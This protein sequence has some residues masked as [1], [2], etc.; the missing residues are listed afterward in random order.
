LPPAAKTQKLDYGLYMG[1]LAVAGLK[2]TNGDLS[3]ADRAFAKS[4][5][6]KN[7]VFNLA[8]QCNS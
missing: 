6:Y 1:Y 5:Q 8:N 7:T 2:L 3:G 4:T